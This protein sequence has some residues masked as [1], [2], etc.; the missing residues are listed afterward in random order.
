MIKEFPPDSVNCGHLKNYIEKLI[1]TTGRKPDAIF[2]DY[3]NLLQPENP[4]NDNTY[5][6]YRF[7]TTEMRRL[8]YVFNTPIISVTQ[9][10]RSGYNSTEPGLDDTSDSYAIPMIADFV[11]GLFQ[12]EGDKDLGRIGCAVLKNRLGG[13]IGKKLEFSIDYN[14]LKIADIKVTQQA[15]ESIVN[16][17]IETIG[18]LNGV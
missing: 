8:S 18:E 12:N 1:S 3:I 7:V 16:D 10:N 9:S 15:P 2:I 6:K 17:V 11:G 4:S 14:N 5:N 13:Q